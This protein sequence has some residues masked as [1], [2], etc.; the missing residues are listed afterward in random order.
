[1]TPLQIAARTSK[2]QQM[3]ALTRT[4]TCGT[5]SQE[6][7]LQTTAMT[8]KDQEMETLAQVWDCGSDSQHL[9]QQP[10]EPTFPHLMDDDCDRGSMIFHPDS[11]PHEQRRRAVTPDL[12]W[13]S[14]SNILNLSKLFVPNEAQISLLEKGLTFIPRP[15]MIDRGALHQDLNIYHRRIKLMEYY[16]D[17]EGEYVPFT[18]PS[19]WEPPWETLS[20]P[21]QSLIYRDMTSLSRYVPPVTQT[22]RLAAQDRR[23]SLELKHNPNIIIKPADKGSKIVILDRQQYLFEA[24]RQLEDIKYYRPITA[25]LCGETQ[26]QVQDIIRR[27]YTKNFITAKQRDFLYGPASPR[28]RLFYLLPKIHK[29]PESWTIPHIIPPGRPIISDCGSVTYNVAQYID[30]FLGPLSVKHPSYLKDTYHFLGKIRDLLLPQEAWLFTIDID[31]LYTNIN[32]EMG[33]GAV[34]QIFSQYPDGT[35]PD[36]EILGLLELCLR[37]N[38]FMFNNEYYLQVEGTAMGHRYAPSYANIYMSGWERGALEKCKLKPD[39]YFR[40]LDDIVGAWSH[41]RDSF[42]EFVEILNNHHPSIK[43]KY[44]L[45]PN[46][47]NFLDTNIFWEPLEERRLKRLLSKVYFKPT[48]THALLHK[49]SYHPK[50]TFKGIVK[51]QI[52]RFH[53][54]CSRTADFD[55][56]VT[57][58][59]S[60]LRNRG[61]SRRFLRTVK[62]QTLAGM[63]EKEQ[64]PSGD[65]HLPGT[66]M[67]MED[68][69]EGGNPSQGGKLRATE[70]TGI[71]PL[72][73][74]YSKSHLPLQI[75]FKNHFTSIL[76]SVETFHGHRIL[77]AFRRNQNLKDILVQTRFQRN[78]VGGGSNDAH[79]AFS[80]RKFLFNPHGGVGATIREKLDLSSCNL[81]YCITCRTCCKMYVGETGGDLLTR[82]KQHIYNIRAAALGTPLVQ[83]FLEHPLRDLTVCGL[84]SNVAWTV[85]QRRR[86]E[87]QWIVRLRTQRPWGLNV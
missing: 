87:A 31:S 37:N 82:L 3:E 55:E 12:S 41:G 83:H 15:T 71:I 25:N 52:I 16:Q 86:Q 20:R 51:S 49:A 23:A 53:R 28:D 40:F 14:S 57:I 75:I 76:S 1:M 50:H 67:V 72:I 74:T 19:C 32:T 33:L 34:K 6:A 43:I 4:R 48:D 38:D 69:R 27:L 81:V 58:L 45:Q 47:I 2:H 5:G 44:D 18:L 54:I 78:I 36:E 64:A 63:R 79:W 10:L 80:T 21:V 66:V 65:P 8:S 59:F 61:Y 77:S 35:R 7:L 84:Q 56:A 24:R 13:G 17:E 9:V 42:L 22:S 62:T 68:E 30:S 60:S 70:T 73:T 26:K 85:G 39:F 11:C 46:N 29:E